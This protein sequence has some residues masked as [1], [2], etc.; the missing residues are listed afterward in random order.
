MVDGP[1]TQ[2]LSTLYGSFAPAKASRP[3]RERDA[4]YPKE[5]QLVG[6]GGE[7]D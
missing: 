4:P 1:D 5:R 6:Y 2:R 7:R 3:V